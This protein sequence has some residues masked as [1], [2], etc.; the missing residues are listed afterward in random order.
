MLASTLV[1]G[2]FA[3]EYGP[4]ILTWDDSEYARSALETVD[5]LGEYGLLSFP[6]WLTTGQHYGK[7][8]LFVDTLA[9]VLEFVGRGRLTT[10]LGLLAVIDAALLLLAVYWFLRGVAPPGYRA[11]TMIAVAGLPCLARWEPAP[12][13]DIQLAILALVTIAMLVKGPRSGWL[14]LV[15]GLGMLSKATFPAL[16]GLPL[17]YWLLEEK[18]ERVERLYRLLPALLIAAVI[19]AAWWLPNLAEARAYASLAYGFKIDVD[20]RLGPTIL[21]WLQTG[22]LEGLSWAVWLALIAALVARGPFARREVR[23]LLLGAAPVLL[24]SLPSPGTSIRFWEPSCVLIAIAIMLLLQRAKPGI[25]AAAAACLVAQWMFTLAVQTPALA[26]AMQ[27]NRTWQQVAPIEPALSALVPIPLTHVNFVLDRVERCGPAAPRNW[28]LSANDGDLNVPRLQL[29]AKMRRLP[30]HFDYAQLFAWSED[31]SRRR[32][33]EIEQQEAMLIT[34]EPIPGNRA[35][36][37]F[38]GWT[39]LVRSELD[40]FRLVEAGLDL[41]LY[42]TPSAFDKLTYRA[43]DG[44]NF[45]GQVLIKSAALEG[46]SL[47]LEV[48]L[49]RPLACSYLFF[50]HGYA[51]EGAPMKIWDKKPDPPFCQWQPGLE[52]SLILELPADFDPGKDRLRM[53]LFDGNDAAHHWPPMD[54]SGGGDAICIN[55]GNGNE[56]PVRACRAGG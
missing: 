3:W 6:V 33:R 10:A 11:L 12:Y 55:P 9:L 37:F 15:L 29:M 50:I 49:L 1:V 26:A 42:A 46:R 14:G 5:Y 36:K 39:D 8:P 23:Y 54:L 48:K 44:F 28:Y 16:V 4:Q 38:M 31:E 47:H 45:G 56:I 2:L 35:S 40:K 20:Q 41:A 32:L 17:L 21:R 7:P 51:G 53:G 43:Q 22:A 34:G 18:D 13:S 30:Q 52:R 19:A 27:A 25:V 24:I